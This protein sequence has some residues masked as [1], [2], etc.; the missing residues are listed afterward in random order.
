[1]AEE[2]A[3]PTN[4]TD[5][6][7]L[8]VVESCRSVRSDQA[9]AQFLGYPKS[10]NRWRAVSQFACGG[11]SITNSDVLAVQTR[12]KL[13]VCAFEG[14]PS[15]PVLMGR[16]P[17]AKDIRSVK[18]VAIERT[19]STSSTAGG[20]ASKRAKRKM[21]ETKVHTIRVGADGVQEFRGVK[22]AGVT[23]PVDGCSGQPST[24]AAAAAAAPLRTG[25]PP[26]EDQDA[27]VASQVDG[28]VIQSA[29]APVSLA[30]SDGTVTALPDERSHLWAAH[31]QINEPNWRKCAASAMP[32]RA[33]AG[34]CARALAAHCQQQSRAPGPQKL[35]G[36][37]AGRVA[38]RSGWRVL[39]RRRAA[40]HATIARVPVPCGPSG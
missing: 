16:L 37:Q 7:E 1:M 9:Y 30:N 8:H 5:E 29:A 3:E 21:Y 20:Q 22:R 34:A 33:A 31:R 18:P 36:W 12:V 32:A 27:V 15:G 10:R 19:G 25:A 26:S 13:N 23:V 11:E 24:A 17:P 40:R 14:V 38:W 2:P 6:H 4:A 35:T 39:V 28:F